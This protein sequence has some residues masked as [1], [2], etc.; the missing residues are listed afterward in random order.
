[1]GKRPNTTERGREGGRGAGAA[2]QA[3]LNEVKCTPL[4][5]NKWGHL[6]D[7]LRPIT[8]RPLPIRNL[9]LSHSLASRKQRNPS[10]LSHSASR[11][12]SCN[13]DSKPRRS[14]RSRL[15]SLVRSLP[16][17]VARLLGRSLVCSTGRMWVRRSFRLT[18]TFFLFEM[19]VNSVVIKFKWASSFRIKILH[20]IPFRAYVFTFHNEFIHQY[21]IV[22][23]HAKTV[24]V[25]VLCMI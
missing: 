5:R 21:C 2:N 16:R 6:P 3:K 18:V 13:T 17:S 9:V 23:G 8:P 7:S 15:R 1:M 14:R 11:S 10:W 22:D 12:Q 20:Y 25:W 24:I 4:G 19:I